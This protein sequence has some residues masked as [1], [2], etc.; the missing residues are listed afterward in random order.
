M[1][2][3]KKDYEEAV[4]RLKEHIN[5]HPSSGSAR[6]IRS[7]ITDQPVR[8]SEL[9]FSLDRENMTAVLTVIEL[10]HEY[11]WPRFDHDEVEGLS[12]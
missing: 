2:D 11:C 5:Q 12:M 4:D 3:R 1:T 10:A 7:A 6:L 9:A 8:L